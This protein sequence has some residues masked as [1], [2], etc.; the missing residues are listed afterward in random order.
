MFSYLFLTLF[1]S[2]TCWVKK[3]LRGRRVN[4]RWQYW[5]YLG[6]AEP[7]VNRDFIEATWEQLNSQIYSVN[8]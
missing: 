2:R 3:R 4:A 1:E 8:Q 5:L 7:Q 6:A